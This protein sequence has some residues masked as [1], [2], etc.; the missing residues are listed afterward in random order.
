MFKN[1]HRLKYQ[2]QARHKLVGGYDTGTTDDDDSQECTP[3]H[4]CVHCST[5]VK[6]ENEHKQ[7]APNFCNGCDKITTHEKLK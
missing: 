4:K 2:R 7:R 6:I 5:E 1:P 3:S